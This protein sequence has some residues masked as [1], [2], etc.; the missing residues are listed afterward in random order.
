ME[1]A[2]LLEN[3]KGMFTPLPPSARVRTI[4]LRDIELP[5]KEM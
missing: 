2:H 3:K 1:F 4:A 5:A